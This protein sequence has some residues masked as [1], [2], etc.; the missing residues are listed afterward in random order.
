MR[1]AVQGM[2]LLRERRGALIREFDR[3]GASVPRSMH[4]L[5]G[6]VSGASQFL[7]LASAD[8]GREPLDSAAFAAEE[9]VEL[10]V[11]T[12]SVAGVQITEIEKG[13]VGR[14]RTGRGHSLVATSARIDAVA[15]RFESVLDRLLEV[16]ALELSV[17][18]PRLSG[19][20]RCRTAGSTTI[21]RNRRHALWRLNHTTPPAVARRTS[22]KAESTRWLSR[23]CPHAAV[24]VD[25]RFVDVAIPAPGTA[26]GAGDHRTVRPSHRPRRRGRV[27]CQNARRHPAVV[28]CSDL[29]ACS[30]SP[31]KRVGATSAQYA[32]E[33]AESSPH[34]RGIPP[35]IRPYTS[36][37]TGSPR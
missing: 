31:H 17:R 23:G 7:G 2:E 6:E 22:V 24:V 32:P 26:A 35:K 19:L 15:E 12:R 36:T 5:D 34:G 28:H 20:P 30:D 3:L 11:R 8:E 21:A 33:P 13:E 29:R 25:D 14:A 27:H 10:T 1:L 37:P 9:G 16:A 18:P 4:L